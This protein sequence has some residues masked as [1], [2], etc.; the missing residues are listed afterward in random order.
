[1]SGSRRGLGAGALRLVLAGVEPVY[2]GAMVVRNR[3]Y[4]AG[5]SRS[6]DL[7][8]PVISI[9]NLTA[10]GTGKTPMVRWLANRLRIQGHRVA[11]LSR[12]Y[13]SAAG[14]LG[15][16]QIMLDRLLNG[17]GVEAI[18]MWANPDRMAAAEA[19]LKSDSS[20]D[21]FVLDDGFQH[22]RV[23]RQMDIVLLSAPEPFGFGHVLPRGLLREPVRGLRRAHAVVITHADEVAESD[24]LAIEKCVRQIHPTVPI[25]RAAHQPGGLRSAECL[26]RRRG[27]TAR[28]ANSNKCDSLVSAGSAIPN[29]STVS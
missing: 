25:H 22:R 27:L 19:A 14:E 23:A 21:V 16:E 12:G 26:C 17:P 8:R 6:R 13:K 5:I 7:R 28:L 29:R 11:V 10:G 15:D 4:D 3:L 1:M 9:G 24:L 20:V 2:A 18:I